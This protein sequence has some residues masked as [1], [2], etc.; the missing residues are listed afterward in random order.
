MDATITALLKEM[1]EE[2]QA[3]TKERTLDRAAASFGKLKTPKLTSL[4]QEAWRSFKTIFTQV[5]QSNG[6]LNIKGELQ[7]VAITPEADKK[8]RLALST[9]FQGT[10]AT[11][12]SQYYPGKYT[13]LTEMIKAIDAH[14]V[15]ASATD[16]AHQLYDE[17]AQK[18]GEDLLKWRG[19]LHLIYT[20]AFPGENGAAC[21]RLKRKYVT[22]LRSSA[23]LG[24]LLAS[25]SYN[26]VT[27]YDI[28]PVFPIY[29]LPFIV[30]TF[31]I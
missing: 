18:E 3:Q 27:L 20:R 17:A 4:D 30:H 1:K 16:H 28:C 22:G 19:R 14:L 29:S 10:T 9:C 8:G 23:M 24:A 11:H 6:W 15:P 5:A 13:D 31:C 2:R 12:L 26:S 25:E 7:P 21:P